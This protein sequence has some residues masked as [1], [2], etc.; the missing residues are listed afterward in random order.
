MDSKKASTNTSLGGLDD[1]SE[2][3]TVIFSELSSN[4]PKILE[5]DNFNATGQNNY[6]II[7]LL[8]EMVS[9]VATTIWVRVMLHVP[10]LRFQRQTRK[11]PSKMTT[12]QPHIKPRYKGVLSVQ[13]MAVSSQLY[14]HH[15]PQQSSPS[16]SESVE[17]NDPSQSDQV[18]HALLQHIKS[19]VPLSQSSLDE[20]ES[21][22]PKEHLC[23]QQ[24]SPVPHCPS[25][26]QSRPTQL[27]PGTQRKLQQLS[28]VEQSS[29]SK[30]SRQVTLTAINITIVSMHLKRA[31]K[32]WIAQNNAETSSSLLPLSFTRPQKDHGKPG[33]FTLPSIPFRTAPPNFS[34]LKA[35]LKRALTPASWERPIDN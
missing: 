18:T 14:W 19:S 17:H 6:R 24:C 21:H 3:I 23:S 22:G 4:S 15:P 13:S 29:D 8:Q 30:Q 27:D 11:T 31:I 1:N 7:Q 5:G 35:I 32:A 26:E 10:P 2:G 33:Q 16:Q 12:V 9:E 25:F 28:S 34:F 20:H